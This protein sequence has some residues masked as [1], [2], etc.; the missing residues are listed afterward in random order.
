M[1]GTKGLI[2]RNKKS[3]SRS[4]ELAQAFLDKSCAEGH[5]APN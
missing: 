2:L 1:D 3:L 4:V 5:T